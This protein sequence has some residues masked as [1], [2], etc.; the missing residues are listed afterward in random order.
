M[1]PDDKK[2]VPYVAPEKNLPEL[3]W[4]VIWLGFL[5]AV[6]FAAA[7]AYLGLYVGM[8]VSASIPAAVISMAIFRALKGNILENNMVKTSAAAGEAVA[9]GIIFTIPA[10]LYLH[11]YLTDG[12]AGWGDLYDQIPVITAVALVGG[13]LGVL[14][15]IPLRRIL[16]I[17]MDLPYPEGVACTEVLK[18]GEQ[19]GRGVHYVFGALGVGAIFKFMGAKMGLRL[20][21]ERLTRIW[22]D[23]DGRVF[24]GTNL[25]P[26]LLGVGW[27]IG[28]RI[29]AMVFGGGVIGWLIAIPL[30]GW[31][32]GW[33]YGGVSYFGEKAI[34]TVWEED[35]LFIGIGAIIVGGLYTMWKMR[36][37]VFT[38]IKQGMSGKAG[39][40]EFGQE[41]PRTERDLPWK[42]WYFALI[43][44]AMLGV[45]WHVTESWV[46]TIVA[47]IV[48]LIMAFFFTAVAGYI[49]GVVGSSNNPVS[50]VTVAT[51]LFT[52]LL[53]VLLQADKYPGMTA[54]I[55]VAA[56]ICV[57]AAIAGDCMQELKTGQL[58]GST[59]WRLQ[60]A[61][62]IGVVAAALIIGPVLWLLDDAYTIF[63]TDL[64]APQGVVMA[65]VVYGVFEGDM[66]WWFFGIGVFLAVA[67]IMLEKFN[68][69]QIS[70]MAVAIGI[71]LPLMLTVP[72]MIG[73]LL[74]MGA[75]SFINN[76]FELAEG[77]QA[78]TPAARASLDKRKTIARED[79]YND[80]VLIASGLIAGEALMG[81][82]IAALIM[83]NLDFT[84]YNVPPDMPG[85]LLYFYIILIMGYIVIRDHVMDMSYKDL[86]ETTI[87]VIG[88]IWR[89]LLAVPGMVI[90]AFAG[91]YWGEPI[92]EAEEADEEWEIEE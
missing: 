53:L 55:I 30:V 62:I 35:T 59:P 66:N 91:G 58:L 81:V 33:E 57:S 45:Y 80:G 21:S 42:V 88:D 44:L 36:E 20:W 69:A 11:R 14:F 86:I 37:A 78:T 50:G 68:I 74:R 18:T 65:T 10:E 1:S 8:T 4:N 51:L 32:R 87:G 16:V 52:S 54:A 82:G 15:S 31:Y 3:T 64:P 9:A 47:A 5:L 6:I 24:F 34:F 61:E 71:Y 23:G 41:L 29:A 89:G 7:N 12:Q 40:D 85:L 17:D 27:I 60:V 90:A 26:A 2:F 48:M 70:I 38:G 92:E 63:S 73:G 46:I 13:I 67:I 77:G 49:A 75:E 19:G 28:P 22:G 84:I 39:V 83:I 43:F 56:I 25:S 76:R 79:S 72:I